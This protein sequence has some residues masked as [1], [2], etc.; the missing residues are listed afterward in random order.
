[1]SLRNSV[2]SKQILRN[3]KDGAKFGIYQMN[4]G[5][6]NYD[7][8]TSETYTRL[9]KKSLKASNIC[10]QS[11][12]SSIERCC[13]SFKMVTFLRYDWYIGTYVYWV[14]KKQNA[15][16]INS[17]NR[18][19]CKQDTDNLSLLCQSSSHYVIKSS[20]K[21]D[22]DVFTSHFVNTFYV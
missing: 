20:T 6:T 13:Q 14:N 18:N 5:Y 10:K 16:I 15:Q 11:F 7:C 17:S 21:N 2:E 9:T 4:E 19:I 8:I 3:V 1:M 12:H 22:Q